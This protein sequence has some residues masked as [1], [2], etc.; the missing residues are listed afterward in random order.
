MSKKGF[1]LS[2]VCERFDISPRTLRRY[3][4]EGLVEVDSDPSGRLLF[5]DTALDTLSKILR[6]KRDLGVNLAGIDIILR[7]CRR[8]EQLQ[9]DLEQ[10]ARET[11]RVESS[12]PSLRPSWPS[13]A[14]ASRGETLYIKVIETDQ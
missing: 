10:I 4:E 6:L 7:L 14:K 1:S 2:Y 8:I 13:P 3:I 11:K 9:R 5:D 12:S